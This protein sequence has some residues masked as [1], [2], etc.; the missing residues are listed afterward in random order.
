MESP[1]PARRRRGAALEGAIFAAVLEELA[2]VGYSR[3]T[4]TAVAQRAGTSKPVLYRRWPGR[5]HIVHATLAQF[6][7]TTIEA[8]DRGSLRGDMIA[9]M[10]S[11]ADASRGIGA[12][13]LWGL[14]AE[15]VD[16]PELFQAVRRDLLDPAPLEAAEVISHRASERGEIGHRS[17]SHRVLA[18]PFEL[19][20]AEALASGS[21]SSEAIEGIVD[22]IVLPLYRA[23]TR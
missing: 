18:L 10:T 3:L 4:L 15:S 9:L 8:P 2:A 23:T 16:D 17:L 1:P 14:L 20:R 19:M 5:A 11:L 21:I 13:A 22:E 6:H 12:D 7:R